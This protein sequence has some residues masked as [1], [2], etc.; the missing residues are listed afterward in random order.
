VLSQAL[1]AE[2]RALVTGGNATVRAVTTLGAVI[3]LTRSMGITGTAIGMVVGAVAQL[4]WQ[5]TFVQRGVFRQFAGWWPR[6]QMVGQVAAYAAAFIMAR[7]TIELIPGY[8]GL[9][10]SLLVGTGVY[11][12]VA[13]L[14]GGLL[15]RDRVRAQMFIDQVGQRLGRRRGFTGGENAV[16]DASPADRAAS[17]T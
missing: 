14:V 13:V 10:V 6:R 4:V 8:T 2:G 3:L 17:V 5:L 12:A 11:F 1:I 16:G 7:A 9:G 15:P